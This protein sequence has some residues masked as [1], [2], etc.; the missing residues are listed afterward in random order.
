MSAFFN[1]ERDFVA[2]LRCIPMVVRF[3]LDQCGIKLALSTWHR[4][5][6]SEKQLLVDLP[7]GVA[8]EVLAYGAT[9]N[10]LI[11]QHTGAAA[12]ALVVEPLWHGDTI[13]P[14]VLTQL[15]TLKLTITPNQWIALTPLQRFVLIKLSRA[16]HENHNFLPALQEFGLV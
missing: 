3:K 5:S 16:N 4:L 11:Q 8:S 1:F 6:E 14:V 12:Q 2:S 10:Q 15:Q 7:C 13:P 9:L